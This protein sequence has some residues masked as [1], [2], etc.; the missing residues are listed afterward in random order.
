MSVV[1]LEAL[2]YGSDPA[3]IIETSN[4]LIYCSTKYNNGVFGTGKLFEYNPQTNTHT[5]AH[6]FSPISTASVSDNLKLYETNGTI[7]GV[8]GFGGSS[9]EDNGVIF[10]FDTSAHTYSILYE[11]SELVAEN[12]TY[13]ST[14]NKLYGISLTGGTN[15]LGILYVYDINT[16]QFTVLQNLTAQNRLVL[17]GGII[18][19]TDIDASFV[20]TD[21]A[22]Y[23]V[24]LQSHGVNNEGSIF[25]IDKATNAFSIEYPFDNSQN[26]TG[27]LPLSIHTVNDKFYGNTNTS[28]TGNNTFFILDS[29][30]LSNVAG[31][32]SSPVQEITVV[33]N[34]KIVA[35]THSELIEYNTATNSSNALFDFLGADFEYTYSVIDLNDTPLSVQ[36]YEDKIGI[37]IFPNPT[38]NIL[39]T[40][41]QNEIIDI[42]LVSLLGQGIEC[43]IKD[44][45]IDITHVPQGMYIL[46]IQTEEGKQT[47]KV[48]KE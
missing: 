46:T 7:Y 21:T 23:G 47:F 13:L 32:D 33:D 26:S 10:S 28:G 25:K 14:E 48:I 18:I 19:E 41:S 4:E 5:L 42:S 40:K 43:N 45:I 36:E 1:N 37:S 34:N 3:D 39:H 38:T 15:N 12:R 44:N 20:E 17:S 8:K 9:N 6:E 11:S 16:N 22:I 31:F 35:T 2:E 27:T 29:G 30:N 24:F